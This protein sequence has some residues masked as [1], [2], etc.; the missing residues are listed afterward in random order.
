MVNRKPVITNFNRDLN[1][2]T[3]IHPDYENTSSY[4]YQWSISLD[5]GQEITTL[6]S[7]SPSTAFQGYGTYC[8]I[9]K[10]SETDCE[11]SFCLPIRDG[12]SG[13]GDCI[14][15]NITES[16]LDLCNSSQI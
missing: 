8:S 5:N 13:G 1:N 3:V 10:D 2:V 6:W 12:N 14:P 7:S 11:T 9:V 4:L 16:N 15:T